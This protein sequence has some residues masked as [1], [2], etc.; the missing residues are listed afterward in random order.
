MSLFSS[1]RREQKEAIGLLQIGTFL[2]YFDLMLYVHM[3]VLLNDLFFP[4]TDPHTASL[5]SAFAFCSTFVLRPF[6]ALLFGYIGDNIGRK[7]TVI[8]TTM[9]MAC[10]CIVM[11]NLPTYSQIGIMAAWILSICRVMQGISSMGEM[12]GAEIYVTEITKPP[13]RYF[14]VSLL[15]IA[16]VLGSTVPLAVASLVTTKGFNWRVAFWIGAGI[17]VVGSIARS[18][19]RE[20]PDFVD[21]KRTM[22]KAI[23]ESN[24]YG[25]GKAADLLKSTNPLWMEKVN[26]ETALSYFLISCAWPTCFYFSFMYCG[27]I[28][29]DTFGFT[30][31]QVIHQNLIVSIVD[32]L[33][34][35][36]I[37]FM[38]QKIHPLKILKAKIMIFFPFILICPYLLSHLN[39]SIELLFIQSFSI[40][41]SLTAIPAGAVFLIHFPIFKRFTA[42]SLLYA[43]S[44]ALMYIVTSFGLIYLIK[45]FGH[46]GLL[47]IMIP[48]GIGFFLGI[49]HFEKLEKQFE[50]PTDAKNLA[51]SFFSV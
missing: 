24:Y 32:L 28:L 33:G 18:R 48:V 8:I 31:E 17:A 23:E 45:L 6:G 34:V 22:K 4:K 36:I 49:R 35:I 2:E 21:M 11:A 39:N 47:F 50:I 37:S 20:T 16:A 1:L 13:E 10:S 9:V 12:V 26:K 41:F 43:F 7:P 5:L 30:G 14:S 3:A 19:L 40:F 29:K 51:E 42:Y 15:N 44:R 25:L 38:S 27:N 46:W